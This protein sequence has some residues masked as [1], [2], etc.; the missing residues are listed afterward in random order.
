MALRVAAGTLLYVTILVLAGVLPPAAGLMLTFPAL[1]GLAFF[2][3]EDG[4]AA[5]IA[6][7]MF[8]MPAINGFL[9]ALYIILFLAIG[10]VSSSALTGWLL[11]LVVA[12]FWYVCVSRKI[13]I[14][15]IKPKHQLAYGVGATL[16]GITLVLVARPW[17]AHSAEALPNE[18]T[19]AGWGH[20]GWIIEAISR[21]R[22]KIVLFALAL[23]AFVVSAAYLPIS[24]A[25]RGILGGLPIVP[26]GGLVSVAGDFAIGIQTRFEILR[27]MLS[28]VWL[29][30]AVAVWF[31]Y[32][33]SRYYSV[34]NVINPEWVDELVRFAAVAAGWIACS[35]VIIAISA[36]INA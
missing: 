19:V 24:D 28:S 21:G 23:S 33:I 5:P 34:R 18:I 1:N 22:F 12:G 29:G 7:T 26:F 31:I 25:T 2:F 9:C 15:G 16:V 4:R 32:Y 3:S 13:V 14:G 10:L 17:I 27:G 8:W 30:P 6:R 36:A 35:A 20:A 11:L